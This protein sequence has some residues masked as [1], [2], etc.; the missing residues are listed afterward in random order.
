MRNEKGLLTTDGSLILR[1]TGELRDTVQTAVAAK[2]SFGSAYLYSAKLADANL[3]Q[4]RL[5]DAVLSY[6]DLS[7]AV[8]RSATLT[9]AN[10]YCADLRRADLTGARLLQSHLYKADLTGAILEGAHLDEAFLRYAKG[11]VSFGPVGKNRRIG[12]A[13]NHGSYAMVKLG[14]FWGTARSAIEAVTEAYGKN[15]TYVRLIRAA[16]AEVLSR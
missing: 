12:Y 11:I 2:V 1:Y 13:V 9:R 4:A 16:V 14:C 5:E 7:G 8:L 15:S 3:T 6:A 10:L